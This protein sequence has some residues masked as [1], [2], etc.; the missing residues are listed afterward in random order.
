[1]IAANTQILSLN[2]ERI[3]ASWPTRWV[4]ILFTFLFVALFFTAQ[5]VTWGAF[6]YEPVEAVQTLNKEII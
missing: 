6:N 2:E 4:I 1:M 5:Q 3:I